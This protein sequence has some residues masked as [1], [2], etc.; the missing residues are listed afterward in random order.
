MLKNYLYEL[1]RH[2]KSQTESITCCA[3]GQWQCE[4]ANLN[5]D[6]PQSRSALLLAFGR[7]EDADLRGKGFDN[8]LMVHDHTNELDWSQLYRTAIPMK[9][10]RLETDRQAALSALNSLFRHWFSAN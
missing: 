9:N 8:V 2:S 1:C 4:K 3:S 7:H 6:Q 10:A 5:S